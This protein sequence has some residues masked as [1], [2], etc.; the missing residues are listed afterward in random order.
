MTDGDNWLDLVSV[1]TVEGFEQ[2]VEEINF[3][4]S[5]NGLE[6]FYVDI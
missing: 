4:Y 1:I 3:V 2:Y 5:I 6:Q